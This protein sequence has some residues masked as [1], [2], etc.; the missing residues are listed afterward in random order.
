MSQKFILCNRN[1][2]ISAATAAFEFWCEISVKIKKKKRNSPQ[3]EIRFRR[4][5]FLQSSL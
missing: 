3:N 1:G 2:H 4:R 5:M